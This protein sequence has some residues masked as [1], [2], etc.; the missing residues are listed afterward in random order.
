MRLHLSLSTEANKH[1]LCCPHA[2]AMDQAVGL[3]HGCIRA[4]LDAHN[5]YE[6]ATEGEGADHDFEYNC[7]TAA[8]TC[9]P[10]P[11]PGRIF[12]GRP[13]GSVVA[14]RLCTSS[15]PAWLPAHKTCPSAPAPARAP[16]FRRRVHLLL[17]CTTRRCRVC[18]GSPGEVAP[19]T[20][21]TCTPCTCHDPDRSEQIR[22]IVDHWQGL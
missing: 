3:H 6:S 15:L 14:L 11:C 21:G 1:I 17:P 4:A 10:T 9:R 2:Q 13:L 5:G 20:L 8:V 19:V 22:P 7:G 12:A 18:N 16:A